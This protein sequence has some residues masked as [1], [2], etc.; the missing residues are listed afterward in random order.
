MSQMPR[1][2]DPRLRAA[3]ALVLVEQ[4]G[5][6]SQLALRDV[7]DAQPPLAGPDRG[8]CT[9]L[10]YGVLRRR[11]ALD[12]WLETS[13]RQGLYDLDE[14][15]LAIL[16]LGALQL[17]DL[18]IPP[19]AAV[20]ATVETAKRL[21]AHK[22]ISFVHA[23][24]RDVAR[25]ML[26]GDRPTHDD[27]PVDGLGNAALFAFNDLLQARDAMGLR[28]FAHFDTYITTAHFVGNGGGRGRT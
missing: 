26:T 3:Q 13:C 10:V 17:A 20:H 23:V 16:R 2:A 15:A 24:L 1:N 12:R 18:R 7:L 8:L 6:G 4:D 11:R 9:E 21:L 19:H 27:L 25:R 22:Q 5:L 14:P 28:V